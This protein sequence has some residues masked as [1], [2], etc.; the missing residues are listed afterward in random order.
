MSVLHAIAEKKRERLDDRKRNVSRNELKARIQEV[1]KPRDFTAAVRRGAGRIRIIAEIKRASPSRGLI[2]KDFDPGQV[3][4]VYEEKSVDA[5][6]VITE[7]DFFLGDLRYIEAVKRIVTRPVLR[8]DFIVDEYQIYE[9]KAYGADAV[10]LIGALLEKA[11]AGEYLD[12]CG[13]LGLSVLFEVH[14]FRELEGALRLD[15]DIIG[16]NN[17]DLKSL[18]VDMETTFLLKREIPPDRITVSESGIKTRDD[19]QRLDAAGIDAM[20]IGTSLIE[21]RDIAG[22]IDELRGTLR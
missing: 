20:L 13:E 19:V 8:K 18:A 10:L 14:D 22:K 15:T 11:Q 2:K 7:E 9:S 4:S 6:S 12:L 21:S 1:E 17:R 16:I 5:V 3:A